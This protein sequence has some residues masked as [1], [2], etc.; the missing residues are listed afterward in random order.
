MSKY[1]GHTPGPWKYNYVREFQ[2]VIEGN[3]GT[4]IAAE[5]FAKTVEQQEAN[6][7]L[8]ADAPMLLER[9]NELEKVSEEG[10]K[11]IGILANDKDKL[12]EQRDKV[13]AMLKW[14]QQKCHIWE[15][16]RSRDNML[17][18]N[19]KGINCKNC[20]LIAEVEG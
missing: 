4:E 18:N 17:Q 15:D 13:L 10:A 11:L 12:L 19:C 7:T 16:Y 3:N 2:C 8:I 1:D 9:V 20:D 5:A 6:A 14:W